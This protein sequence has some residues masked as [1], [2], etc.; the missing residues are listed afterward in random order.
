MV[1]Q[2]RSAVPAN[3]PHEFFTPLAGIIGLMEIL[4]TDLAHAS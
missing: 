1:A 2:L 3:L 4:R